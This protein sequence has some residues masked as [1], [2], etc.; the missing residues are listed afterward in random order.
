M[1]LTYSDF[2]FLVGFA[3][4]LF[5]VAGGYIMGKM[6]NIEEDKREKISNSSRN[7]KIN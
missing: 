5:C 4:A 2:S 6:F 3:T 1:T 7:R